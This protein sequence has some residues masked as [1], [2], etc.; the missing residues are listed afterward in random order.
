VRTRFDQLAK[1][2]LE[3]ALSPLGEVRTQEEI[4]GEVQAADVLFRPVAQPAIEPDRVGLLG[5]MARTSCLIEPFHTTARPSAVLDCIDKHLTLRRK[6]VRAARK[7]GNKPDI[8]RLWVLSTGRPRSVLTD[9]R[10]VKLRGWPT[11]V[12]H[13]PPLLSLYLVVLSDLPET[14][15]TLPLRLL[16]SGATFWRAAY[17]V[18][19]MPRDQWESQAFSGKLIA[20]TL[21]IL[22][23]PEKANEEDV[24]NAIDYQDMY[25]QWERDVLAEGRKEGIREAITG[26]YQARFGTVPPDV[27]IAVHATSDTSTLRRWNTLVATAT[28]D[29]I[30]AALQLKRTSRTTRPAKSRP[31]TKKSSR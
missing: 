14:R 5:R 4:H 21:D 28:P 18:R 25:D 22:Q 27:V 9:L 8:P 10:F 12:W 19:A 1:N 24:R 16:A 31:R 11:G 26:T 2:V 20:Y 17:E 13:G 15:D 6:R 23:N 30:A 29:E 7:A 3:T